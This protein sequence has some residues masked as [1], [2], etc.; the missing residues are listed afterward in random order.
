LDYYLRHETRYG[1][2]ITWARCFPAN[3]PAAQTAH[4]A[5]VIEMSRAGV[6][7]STVILAIKK[8]PVKFDVSAEGI[9]ALHAAGITESVLNQM[10]RAS[11]EDEDRLLVWSRYGYVSHEGCRWQDGTLQRLDQD[12]EC[13]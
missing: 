8:K 3:W 2:A 11:A 9:L 12:R 13:S 5:D 4:H 6:P 1:A 7:E 10:L